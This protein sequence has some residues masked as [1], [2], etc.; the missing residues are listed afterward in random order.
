MENILGGTEMK[1]KI[2]SIMLSIAIVITGIQLPVIKK[3][4]LAKENVL[5]KFDAYYTAHSDNV[6]DY[7][8]KKV[9]K[10]DYWEEDGAG[11]I[12]R[13]AK[14]TTTETNSQNPNYDG[15]PYPDMAMLYY[16][17]K[18]YKDFTVEVEYKN[19][20][21]GRGAAWLGFGGKVTDDT[22]NTWCTENGATIFGTSGEKTVKLIGTYIPWQKS[23]KG[24]KT[25]GSTLWDTDISGA[26]WGTE[27]NAVKIIVKDGVINFYTKVGSEWKAAWG[28]DKFYYG[29]WYKGGYIFLASNNAGTQFRNFKIEEIKDTNILKN[30]N[31]YYTEDTK[32]N[33]SV[34][35]V[36][37]KEK[38]WTEDEN[39]ILTRTSKNT[40]ANV[41]DAYKNMAYLFYNVKEYEEFSLEVDY[42]NADPKKGGAWVGFDGKI[43]DDVAKTWFGDG[44]GTMI[45]AN[46][47][48]EVNLVGT[49]GNGDKPKITTYNTTKRV[50]KTEVEGADWT[51]AEWKTIKIEV[52]KGK[53]NFQI[54]NN[55]KWYTV[56]EKEELLYDTWYDGGYIFLASNHAGTQFKNFKLTEYKE[57]EEFRELKKFESYYAKDIYNAEPV[58]AFTKD[59]WT[60][61]QD[62]I[63]TRKTKDVGTENDG[64]PYPNMALLY[65]NVSQYKDFTLEVEIKNPIKGKAS[66]WVGFDGTKGKSWLTSCNGTMISAIGESAV[67]LVGS[68]DAYGMNPFRSSKSK[69]VIWDYWMDDVKNWGTDWYKVK[70]Q[71]LDGEI[72]FFYNTSG[73]WMSAW[74]EESFTYD[75]W[76]NGG[77]VFLACNSG[78]TSFRNFKVTNATTKKSVLDKFETW[79]TVGCDKE[80][81]KKVFTSHYWEADENGVITRKGRDVKKGE[82]A[83][84]G[85]PYPNMAYLFYNTKK[86]KD[87]SLEV[88]IKSPTD[89]RSSAW[90]GYDGEKGK[91]WLNKLGGTM[92]STQGDRVVKMVG[93]FDAYNH[94]KF[95]PSIKTPNIWDYWMENVE[96]WGTDWYKLKIEVC[97]GTIKYFYKVKKSGK[98]SPWLNA[99]LE[100]A[101]T[102]DKW[103]DGGYIFLASNHAGTQFRNL[104]VKEIKRK[105]S[106]LDDFEPY[107]TVGC[108]KQKPKAT[109]MSYYW[110]ADKNGVITRKGMD[111]T[112]N[113]KECNDGNPYPNMAILYSKKIYKDFTMNLEYKNPAGDRGGAWIGFDGEK[114]KTW[115]DKNS[116][117]MWCTCGT[118]GIKMAGTFTAYNGVKWDSAL[119][120]Y[121]LDKADFNA[122]WIKAKLVVKNGEIK[123]YIKIKGKWKLTWDTADYANPLY[124]TDWYDGGRI[125]LAANELGVQY[126]NIKIKEEKST[127]DFSRFNS[128]YSECVEN[129]PLVK[130]DPGKYWYEDK[131][132]LIRK[133]EE[134]GE[135]KGK[136]WNLSN[137]QQN[138]MA[139]MFLN[140]NYV[141]SDNWQLDVDVTLG[142]SAWKRF[143]I[144]YGATDTVTWR[145]PNGGTVF[146]TDD[147]GGVCMEGNYASNEQIYGDTAESIKNFEKNKAHHYRIVAKAGV[148]HLYIDGIQVKEYV[149]QK[150]QKGGRVFFASNSVNTTFSNISI[151]TLESDFSQSSWSGYKEYYSSDITKNALTKV[152]EGTNWAIEDGVIRRKAQEPG[153]DD[154]RNYLDMA[155]LYLNDKKYT[156]F[157]LELDYKNGNSG[158]HRAPIGFG[159]KMGRHFIEEGG[160]ITALVQ[161]DGY[162]HFDGNNQSDGAF[163]EHVFWPVYDEKGNDVSTLKPYDE[164]KWHHMVME[165]ADGYVTVTVD[166]FKYVYEMALPSYYNGGYIYL[167]ANSVWAEYKNI[168]IEDYSEMYNSDDKGWIPKREDIEYDFEYR[169]K[170]ENN[171]IWSWIYK[172][173]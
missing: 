140:G 3:A 61:N 55:G 69:P 6:K 165:V 71:V 37:S 8:A 102:Y 142:N 57:S 155:Y 147:N 20:N 53:I 25:D 62:G 88:D 36:V 95:R 173:L 144:G 98:W 76:Y 108:D 111:L 107:Y 68:F 22:A 93:S 153:M 92:L 52:K 5:N 77:Y 130:V 39:G 44:Q 96:N 65:Y 131:G 16:N 4:V 139:Y 86:Y 170:E 23:N 157:K 137:Y 114:G 58:P 79:Y 85:N 135:F 118:N 29:D 163:E 127:N 110:K 64:N 109:R 26:D 103:Y 123:Y 158:W 9:I 33:S 113:L 100:D 120:D 56:Y 154:C 49:F 11:V 148:V 171:S 143:Y 19:P 116:G 72:K 112:D 73:K 60:E 161:P 172:E 89:K 7:P 14:D 67:K 21:K 166:G 97:D 134:L 24:A 66:A 27:W 51:K 115:T 54:K 106:I 28:D 117:T 87:F 13:T 38:Y 94:N 104:K 80:K 168:K 133:N 99:W 128:Y 122:R 160:G 41:G 34:A 121:W 78:G 152:Q 164:T 50:W 17:I 105:N 167:A 169:E 84:D 101:F 15:N 70:I 43:E 159:A 45:A 40:T 83:N 90:V 31:G 156:N 125:F 46:G 10:S 129:Q 162:V 59:Y 146:W 30:F 35:D 63:I 91:T 150:Y 32:G 126:R 74:P 48:N 141:Y 136:E 151:K 138:K 18:Q 2:I 145:K 75:E 47:K 132:V 119:W 149:Q 42:K 82:D 124:Y 81:P 1:R 12:T